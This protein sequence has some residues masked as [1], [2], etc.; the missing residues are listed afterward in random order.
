VSLAL[1][2]RRTRLVVALPLAAVVLLALPASSALLRA[3]QAPSS[4]SPAAAAVTLPIAFEP[5]AG[6]FTHGV[7]YVARGRG[8]TLSLTRSAAVLSLGSARIR[9]R[10]LG[11]HPMAPGGEQRRRGVVNWY[12][13]ADRSKWRSGIPTFGAVRYRRIYPGTD[14]IYHGRDGALEYDFRLAPG[15]DPRAIALGFNAAPRL[16]PNGDLLLGT[17]RQL[18]PVAYQTIDGRRMPVDAGF[19]LSGKRVRF[20][21]GRYDKTRPLVIDPQF[22]FKTY[23]GGNGTDAVNGLAINGTHLYAGGPGNSS[24][25]YGATSG[26]NGN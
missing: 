1:W 4:A 24:G 12:M 6:R 19:Q 22:A 2:P 23:A 25:F 17:T 16:A 3:P 14:L 7:E 10:L 13:G 11:A 20:R 8:Y 18:K 21:V 5:S 15:A 9:T 26:S